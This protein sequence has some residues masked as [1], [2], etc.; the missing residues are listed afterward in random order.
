MTWNFSTSSFIAGVMFG[1]LLAGAWFLGGDATRLS[2]Q[3]SFRAT[4]DDRSLSQKSGVVSVVDQS[5]GDTVIV[6]SVTVPA[7]G[8]WVAVREMSGN[9]LGNVLGA[10]RVGGPRDAVTVSLL[11]ATEPNRAYAVQL[12]RDDNNGLFDP[13]M[14][15]VYV[16]F[17][18]GARVVAYFA[19]I[20]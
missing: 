16:D 19:T 15:S 12:Y 10:V 13:S 7:P 11:R 17:T 18:T 6:A 5:A 20:E 14:N 2:E 8:V 9:D 3:S 1:A 4:A